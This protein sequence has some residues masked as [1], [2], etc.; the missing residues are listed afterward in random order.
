MANYSAP[1]PHDTGSWAGENRA[2]LRGPHGT[3]DNAKVNATLDA[4]LFPAAVQKPEGYIVSGTV[5]ARKT[6]TGYIGAYDPTGSDGLNKP[7]GILYNTV[8]IKNGIEHVFNALLVHG[9][10]NE[11]ELPFASGMGSLDAAARTALPHIIVY[12]AL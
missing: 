10:V 7:V 12:P 6:S 8:S 5:A 11:D 3:D 4:S 9:T 2:W 1:A